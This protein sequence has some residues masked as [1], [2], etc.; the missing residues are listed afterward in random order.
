MNVF[1]Y[2]KQCEVKDMKELEQAVQAWFAKNGESYG[3]R[4]LAILRPHEDNLE[5]AQDKREINSLRGEDP[6]A[7]LQ[8]TWLLVGFGRDVRMRICLNDIRPAFQR[9]GKQA[10]DEF[11]TEAMSYRLQMDNI[12]GDLEEYRTAEEYLILRVLPEEK[13]GT[14]EDDLILQ[15]IGD[16]ALVLYCDMGSQDGMY[17]SF[18]VKRKMIGRWQMSDEEIL[19][20]ALKN[21]CRKYPAVIYEHW[22]DYVQRNE[23]FTYPGESGELGDDLILTTECP[24]NGAIA[25]F[26]PGV[27]EALRRRTGE[28]CIV[29]TG[30]DEVNIRRLEDLQPA[31]AVRALRELNREFADAKLSE[32]L[33]VFDREGY[34]VPF[35]FG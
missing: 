13:I 14:A 17:R 1:R 25:M 21:T 12:A 9:N 2:H 4:V 6:E 18:R 8:D 19:D 22:Q 5:Y 24:V 26:Y 15:R 34:T 27:A 3:A 11:L 31:K 28:V 10:V 23:S 35:V 20:A 33:W 30:M 7:S 16:I 32:L 29:P